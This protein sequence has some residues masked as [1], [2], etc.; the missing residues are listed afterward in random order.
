MIS[1]KLYSEEL[2]FFDHMEDV[3]IKEG[4]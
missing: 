2:F 4:L 3:E 1:D